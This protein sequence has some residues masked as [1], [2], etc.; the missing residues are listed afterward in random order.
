MLAID[1]QSKNTKQQQQ[2]EEKKRNETLRE[3]AS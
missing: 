3:K 1:G 2:K